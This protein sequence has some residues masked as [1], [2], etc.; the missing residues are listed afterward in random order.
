[1]AAIADRGNGDVDVNIRAAM[2]VTA[3]VRAGI[4]NAATAVDVVAETINAVFNVAIVLLIIFVISGDGGGI[5]GSVLVSMAARSRSSGS[6]P[7]RNF[8][9]TKA[10]DN[11][12]T[13][14]TIDKNDNNKSFFIML[15]SQ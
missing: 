13:S 8:G 7:S 12:N 5:D 9:G 15:V 6:D 10:N 11:S 4:C 3:D 1:M 14:S 2:Y